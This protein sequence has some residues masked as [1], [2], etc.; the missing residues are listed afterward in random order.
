MCDHF[1]L[2]SPNRLNSILEW[3]ATAE[4]RHRENTHLSS[5]QIYDGAYF[6]RDGYPLHPLLP[7]FTPLPPLRPHARNK[8]GVRKLG[9]VSSRMTLVLALPKRTK[10][11]LPLN[12]C[13]VFALRSLYAALSKEKKPHSFHF[14]TT[15]RLP[16]PFFPRFGFG[17]VKRP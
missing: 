11:L 17:L 7:P 5:T 2:I 15:Q 9:V 4:I 3:S 14:L 6:S 1:T 12:I 16:Q 13:V 8:T 10:T